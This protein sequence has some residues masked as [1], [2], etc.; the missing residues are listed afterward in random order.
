MGLQTTRPGIVPAAFGRGVRFAN[1]RPRE[2]KPGLDGGVLTSWQVLG[3][4]A[5]SRRRSR[6]GATGSQWC[7][8]SF[9]ASFGRRSRRRG[10]S[11]A[12]PG[13]SPEATA[14][15]G[16]GTVRGHKLRRTPSPRLETLG[17]RSRSECLRP[18]AARSSS[19]RPGRRVPPRAMPATPGGL[20]DTR[21]R[22]ADSPASSTTRRFEARLRQED[23]P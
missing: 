13:C 23:A 20:F 14:L 4:V 2:F 16:G 11:V 10:C 12:K 8:P 22:R 3:A 6:S 18:K 5:L 9:T 1:R 17:R 19:V 21:Y 15:P 7:A